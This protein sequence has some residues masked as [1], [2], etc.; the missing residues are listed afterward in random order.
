MKPRAETEKRRRKAR[1]A[2]ESA[3][4][5]RN[6]LIAGVCGGAVCAWLYE[7]ESLN[8]DGAEEEEELLGVRVRVMRGK[9]R[10]VLLVK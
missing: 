6:R 2:K 1:V 3:S 7:R 10:N 9:N 4:W 5:R 8:G